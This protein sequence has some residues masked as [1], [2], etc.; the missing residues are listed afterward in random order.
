MI[1]L[2][3]KQLTHYLPQITATAMITI[4]GLFLFK[5]FIT[6]EYFPVSVS[7]EMKNSA[8]SAA[9]VPTGKVFVCSN[10]FSINWF[11][12]FKSKHHHHFFGN[13]LSRF[14]NKAKLL[15]VE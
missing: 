6:K 8:G 14:Q 10:D 9:F 11:T 4:A 15:P 7:I 13:I 12:H 2:A 3:K 1:R 5:F